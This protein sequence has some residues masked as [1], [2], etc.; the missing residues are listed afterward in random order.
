M[1]VG[2][3]GAGVL[4][5]VGEGLLD[6]P[7]RGELDARGQ[8]ARLAVGPQPDVEAGVPV[9]GDQRRHV[10]QRG[11]GLEDGRRSLAIA[12]AAIRSADE[13]RHIRL[14]GGTP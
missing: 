4:H 5:R 9:A 2:A 10:A 7:E 1:R 13:G 6:D 3:C 8:R 11:L 14:D 12:L